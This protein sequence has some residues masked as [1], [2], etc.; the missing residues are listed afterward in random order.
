[1]RGGGCLPC[2]PGNSPSLPPAGMSGSGGGGRETDGG[3][4][5]WGLIAPGRAHRPRTAPWPG[6]RERRGPAVA[7]PPDWASV[8]SRSRHARPLSPGRDSAQGQPRRPC[9]QILQRL[10]AF[11][12]QHVDG[13]GTDQLLQRLGVTSGPGCQPLPQRGAELVLQI[14]PVAPTQHLSEVGQADRS[15]TVTV[16]VR[17]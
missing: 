6:R 1:M 2:R 8:R 12:G 11:A 15:F 5:A 17:P 13:T 16:A 9:Q 14:Q 10:H 3:L 7:R 4:A